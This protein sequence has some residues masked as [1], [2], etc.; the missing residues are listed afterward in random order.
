MGDDAKQD[1]TMSEKTRQELKDFIE[2]NG[3]K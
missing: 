3:K 2:K 1:E